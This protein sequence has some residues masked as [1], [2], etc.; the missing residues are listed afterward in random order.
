[1]SI[2]LP[3]CKS[4]EKCD[5]YSIEDD[6]QKEHFESQKKYCSIETIK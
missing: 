1:M 3:S 6:I 4:T 2:T 5:S